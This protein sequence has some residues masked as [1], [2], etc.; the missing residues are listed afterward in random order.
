MKEVVIG[1]LLTTREKDPVDLEELSKNVSLVATVENFSELNIQPAYD[2]Y[3]VPYQLKPHRD[4]V[5]LKFNEPKAF[6]RSGRV[7]VPL[8]LVLGDYRDFVSTFLDNI[9]HNRAPDYYPKGK[10]I[11]ELLPEWGLDYRDMGRYFGFSHLLTPDDG[12]EI[13]FVLNKSEHIA[14]NMIGLSGSTPDFPD[15]FNWKDFSYDVFYGNHLDVEMKEEY[16]LRP[17]DFDI[18][19]IR[20]LDPR[21]EIPHAAIQIITD[22]TTRQI[23]ELA[24]GHEKPLKEHS[25]FFSTDKYGLSKVMEQLDIHV[26]NLFEFDFLKD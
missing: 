26:P 2:R 9:P 3:E 21:I 4:A 20:L 24:Y 10:T 17:D 13:S 11:G 16:N 8:Q 12:R 14:T 18:G 7:E 15:R 25:I 1:N 23:A 6:C 19:L 5:K 22:Y